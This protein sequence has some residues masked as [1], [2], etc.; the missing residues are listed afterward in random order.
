LTFAFDLDFEFG[1]RSGMEVFLTTLS[2]SLRRC[3]Q[4]HRNAAEPP[5]RPSSRP[6]FA[7]SRGAQRPDVRALCCPGFARLL[8]GRYVRVRGGAPATGWLF[9]LVRV[10]PSDT[11]RAGAALRSEWTARRPAWWTGSLAALSSFTYVAVAWH[12]QVPAQRPLRRNSGQRLLN[13]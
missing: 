11:T 5:A 6:P 13:G 2:C 9:M 8:C 1:W 10:M 12:G 3:G 7:N 4:E